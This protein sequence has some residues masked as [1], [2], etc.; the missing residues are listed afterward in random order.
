M[1]S[2]PHYLSL[3]LSVVFS[4]CLGLSLTR[5]SS[6][7]LSLSLARA[8]T[9][10]RR[11]IYICALEDTIGIPTCWNG[12]LQSP[13]V[14]VSSHL[15][16]SLSVSVSVPHSS[17][18]ACGWFC[19]ARAAQQAV[20]RAAQQAV[21]RCARTAGCA[22]LLSHATKTASSTKTSANS[23]AVALQLLFRWA[24][25]AHPRQ[26]THLVLH[27]SVA[28]PWPIHPSRGKDVNAEG[29]GL[30]RGGGSLI[31]GPSRGKDAN[32]EGGGLWRGGGSLTPALAK[33]S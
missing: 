25:A 7:A 10:A 20:Q 4:F 6:L 19:Q 9:L 13:S 22:A 16:L 8:L 12:V 5:R 30:W 23:V 31:P 3:C 11:L 24:S 18:S 27:D 2:C 1:V 33:R 15:R 32:A 26:A 21:K 14:I 17:R 28:G 29:G